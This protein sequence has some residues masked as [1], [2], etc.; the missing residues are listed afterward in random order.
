MKLSH[1]IG[2][3]QFKAVPVMNVHSDGMGRLPSVRQNLA[4]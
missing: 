1:P 2:M 4:F 3:G